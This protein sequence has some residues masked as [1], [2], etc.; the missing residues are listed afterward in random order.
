[1]AYSEWFPCSKSNKPYSFDT[2]TDVRSN[3]IR[4]MKLH[5]CGMRVGPSYIFKAVFSADII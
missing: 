4:V 1:M 2:N 5:Y 3:H